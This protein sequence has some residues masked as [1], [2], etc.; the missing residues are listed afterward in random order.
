MKSGLKFWH[1]M[2]LISAGAFYFIFIWKNS[3]LV[4]HERY[5]S[6]FDDAMVA[7]RYAKNLADGYGLRWNPGEPPVEGYTNLLWT[8]YMAAVHLLPIAISKTSLVVSLSG[9]AILLVNLVLVKKLTEAVT[10][11]NSFAPLSAVFLTAFYYPL[12]Y[13]TL[14]GME[15]GLLCLLVNY[16]ALCAFRLYDRYS[17]RDVIILTLTLVAGLLTRPDMVIP[18]AVMGLFL[19][20]VIRRSGFKLSYA[21]I[22]AG[23]VAAGCGL[24]FFQMKYYGDP[25]PNT[26]YLKVAGVTALERASRGIK[27]LMEL[28]AYH[29]WPVLLLA[30][31]G[32]WKSA[33][34][35]KNPKLI[36]LLGMFLCQCAYSVYVGGDA[37]EWMHFSNRYIAIAVPAL[38]IVVSTFLSDPETVKIKTAIVFLPALG[39]SLLAEGIYY[40]REDTREL[41]TPGVGLAELFIVVGGAW[42]AFSLL[43]RRR[44]VASPVFAA[45]VA[46]MA[47]VALNFF[48]ITNWVQGTNNGGLLAADADAVREGLALRQVTTP[49]ARIAYI[50]AGAMP[51]FAGRKAIDLLG[52]SDPVIAKGKPAAP[53]Y[54]GHSK[55]NYAYSIGQLKPDI[56]TILW[57]PT[58]ADKDNMAKWGYAISHY[59]YYLKDSTNINRALVKA[60]AP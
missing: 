50:A 17:L 16:A 44:P 13:W 56:V 34:L 33:S 3:F 35:R 30:S 21:I 37:W 26:Y 14:R 31:V 20:H 25:V 23:I 51:Y 7:M 38:F 60:S 4:G 1:L 10:G 19:L 42:M 57:S 39:L 52:K 11:E 48:G 45:M 54:P 55:W 58:H 28:F 6:L 43:Y 12:I 47:G 41:P 29:L 22:P 53:F 18:I 46:V 36:L 9:A 2:C 59:G 5:F 8:L 27:V 24:T 49:T 40:F 15:V 32:F